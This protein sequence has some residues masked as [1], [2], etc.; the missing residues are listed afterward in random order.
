MQEDRR[1]EILAKLSAERQ[2]A[3]KARTSSSVLAP[4]RDVFMKFDT[5]ASQGVQSANTSHE[6]SHMLQKLFQADRTSGDNGMSLGRI[7]PDHPDA[8]ALEETIPPPATSDD[9]STGSQPSDKRSQLLQKLFQ[10]QDSR[11]NGDSSTIDARDDF[12]HHQEAR[13]WSPSFES[14]VSDAAS[15]TSDASFSEQHNDADE[16]GDDG[17]LFYASDILGNGATAAIQPRRQMDLLSEQHHD[18]TAVQSSRYD[19]SDDHRTYLGDDHSQEQYPFADTYEAAD[20]DDKDEPLENSDS[21]APARLDPA[22]SMSFAPD[23][24]VFEQR[25]QR[26]SA[27]PTVSKR[28]EFLAQPLTDKFT[29]RE[30][31]RIVQEMQSFHECTFRPDTTKSK[32]RA[33][34]KTKERARDDSDVGAMRERGA[35]P[36]LMLSPRRHSSTAHGNR[37]RVTWSDLETPAAKQSV[38]E[39][40]HLDGTAKYELRE[41]AKA[42]LEAQT[43]QACTF[44]PQ[45]NATSRTLASISGYKPIHE[46]VSDIQRAKVR[47]SVQMH[48]PQRARV[49]A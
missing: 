14:P 2:A 3:L 7:E 9:S 43:L 41:Q 13:S 8:Q 35:F 18:E 1:K 49:L 30:K 4:P 32:I 11:F 39:R 10:G 21:V 23:F 22:P 38:V 48:T 36:W 27:A 20:D 19:V 24:D 37:A 12:R 29:A 16:S 26:H 17:E 34:S 33:R 25:A 6:R 5:V 45:I 31:Q 15:R 42:A 28:I 40:L 47:T 44:R 46:R